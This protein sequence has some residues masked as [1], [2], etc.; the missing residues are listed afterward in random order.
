[1]SRILSAETRA[2]VNST[3]P[4]LQQHGVAISTGDLA[5]QTSS[6]GFVILG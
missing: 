2:I 6:R 5:S 3:A 4:A 1:M